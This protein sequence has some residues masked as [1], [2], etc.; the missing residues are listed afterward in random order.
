MVNS[1][2][3]T[4]N[5]QAA[6]KNLTSNSVCYFLIPISTDCLLLMNTPIEVSQ[7][8]AAWK[9]FDESH[10]ATVVLNGLFCLSLYFVPGIVFSFIYFRSSFG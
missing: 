7:L 2:D 4:L 1:Q 6:I 3:K 8:V 5:V 9:G 10:E